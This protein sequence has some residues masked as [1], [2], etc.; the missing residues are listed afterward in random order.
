MNKIATGIY[1]T[2][3][4]CNKQDRITRTKGNE[5]SETENKNKRN[6]QTSQMGFY[7]ASAMTKSFRFRQI[8]AIH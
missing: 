5:R 7:I 6:T 4:V 8:Q 1:S 3:Y 2:I